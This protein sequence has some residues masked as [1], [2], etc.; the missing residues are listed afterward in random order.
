MCKAKKDCPITGVVPGGF[1]EDVCLLQMVK[2]MCIKD[3]VNFCEAEKMVRL[4]KKEW[5][6]C[7]GQLATEWS[8]DYSH[9]MD[10]CKGQYLVKPER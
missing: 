1:S 6:A 2:H 7:L 9:P 4:R 5:L 8:C 10:L 3:G